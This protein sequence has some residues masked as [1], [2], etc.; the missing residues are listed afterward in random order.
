MTAMCCGAAR[1]LHVLR[2]TTRLVAHMSNL[3][4]LP[5]SRMPPR[6]AQSKPATIHILHSWRT[7]YNR[8]DKLDKKYPEEAIHWYQQSVKV[9]ENGR[10]RA[11]SMV[12]E[13]NCHYR[14]DNRHEAQRLY[15]EAMQENPN[16]PEAWHNAG[17]LLYEDKSYSAAKECF[18]E[19]LVLEPNFQD[20]VWYIQ[21]LESKGL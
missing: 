15:T 21:R 12:N 1:T 18:C 2:P 7:L 4:I 14:L 8:A 16:C 3:L 6:K 13:G 9:A 5:L 11:L 19:A 17:V 10:E 20:S